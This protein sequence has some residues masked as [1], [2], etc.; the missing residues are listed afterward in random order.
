MACSA[1]S[2]IPARSSLETPDGSTLTYGGLLQ[3]TA[4]YANALAA[5]GAEARRPGGRPGR[6]E[7]RGDHPLSRGGAGGRGL[8]AAQHGLHRR[9]ARLFHRRCRAGAGDRRSRA[10]RGDRAHRAGARRCRWRRSTPE[11]AEAVI[12]RARGQQTEFADAER[13]PDDLAALAL[14]LRHDRALQGRHADP[15][16]PPVQCPGPDRAIGASRRTTCCCTRCRSSI[17]TACSWRPM[18]SSSPALR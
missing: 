4:R 9:R 12:E 8:P 11:A 15:G 10:A 7:P 5:Q 17:P 6:E 16:Q 13:G 1:G 2:P 3:D 14:H 18:W